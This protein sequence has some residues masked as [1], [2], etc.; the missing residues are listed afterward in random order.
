M[1]TRQRVLSPARLRLHTAPNAWSN[2]GSRAL[3]RAPTTLIACHLPL[4]RAIA[5]SQV[6]SWGGPFPRSQD[7]N[8]TTQA[9]TRDPCAVGGVPVG[10]GGSAWQH[11]RAGRHIAGQHG[12]GHVFDC[13][14]RG[15]ERR[16][17]QARGVL[18]ARLPDAGEHHQ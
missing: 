8:L 15:Q 4:R 16:M 9:R 18:R 5:A 13:V 11:D 7:G 17:V 12:P 3:T 10:L 14:L 6:R 2:G 1:N